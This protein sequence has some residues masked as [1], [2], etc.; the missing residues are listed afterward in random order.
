L[1]ERASC[2]VADALVEHDRP[3]DGLDDLEQGDILRL[4]CQ[5]HAAAR[6]A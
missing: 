6:A 5:G 3:V 4:A 2:V 1:I